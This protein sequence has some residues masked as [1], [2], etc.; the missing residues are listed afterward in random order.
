M[1]YAKSQVRKLKAE[2]KEVGAM[3]AKNQAA[4]QQVSELKTRCSS[5]EVSE[6]QLQAE[7]KSLQT[8]FDS[9][10]ETVSKMKVQM[11]S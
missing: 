1:T 10:E 5:L 2:A 3:L 11:K 9:L 7:K 6:L 4:Q 8:K